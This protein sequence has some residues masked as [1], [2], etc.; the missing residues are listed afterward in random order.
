MSSVEL[1][2]GPAL[3][4]P[5]F[6]LAFLGERYDHVLADIAGWPGE[7]VTEVAVFKLLKKTPFYVVTAKTPDGAY[8]ALL[9][10]RQITKI[11]QI[12]L[13]RRFLAHRE[14][15]WLA[16]DTSPI[17]GFRRYRYEMSWPKI[18]LADFARNED[19][20]IPATPRILGTICSPAQEAY[21]YNVLIFNAAFEKQLNALG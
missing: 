20:L 3:N 11:H 21:R 15:G 7:Q 4:N 16:H 14:T 12:E 5:E 13:C 9:T 17:F 18:P 1:Q 8:T 2:P 10:M 6:L 19:L